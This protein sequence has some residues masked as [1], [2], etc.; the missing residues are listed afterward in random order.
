ME[1][2]LYT[3]LLAA[4]L[5]FPKIKKDATNP[6]FKNKYASLDG[7]LEVVLPILHKN[8]LVLV[9]N[10]INDGD[11]IGIH[12]QIFHT[13][14]DF[15]ES[16]FTVT[17]A[18]NDPQGA[19]SAI[20]Y[21]RRYALT[22]MLGLNVEEDDDANTASG[23]HQAQQARPAQTLQSPTPTGAPAPLQTIKTIRR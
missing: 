8:A 20:T 6:F 22:A 21:C 16:K 1:Q 18:K 4:Q 9:Q 11:R 5:E 19:G 17:L 15:I 7:M 10:P 23:N 2:T 12:T 14:G 3:Q 13:D